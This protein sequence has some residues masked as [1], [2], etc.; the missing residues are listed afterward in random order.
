MSR[1]LRDIWVLIFITTVWAAG[2]AH[3][4]SLS[5]P[6]R[7]AT[8]SGREL[9]VGLDPHYPPVVYKVQDKLEGIE[10]EL[11]RQLGQALNRKIVFVETRWEDLIPAL[12]RGRFDVIMSGMSV[13]EER[14]NLILFTDPYMRIG[15]MAVIREA[16]LENFRSPAAIYGTT[17]RVGFQEATTGARFVREHLRQ[18]VFVP[19]ESAEQGL[20][21]LRSGQIDLFIHDAPTVWRLAADLTNKDLMGLYWPLTEESLAWGLRKSDEDL[22]RELN[23]RLSR[24][25]ESGRLQ[26][27]LSKWIRLRIEVQ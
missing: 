15:Q 14:Q 23:S 25:K 24:W 17:A 4:G 5:P 26:M 8:N 6:S 27:I 13:T 22:R 2:C 7:L 9:R 12:N 11:A 1:I 20:A 10:V 21:A 18:A 3:N 16:D 19:Q